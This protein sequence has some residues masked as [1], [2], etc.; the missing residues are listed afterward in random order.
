MNA[1]IIKRTYYAGGDLHYDGIEVV[2]LT[3]SGERARKR[4]PVERPPSRDLDVLGQ[5]GVVVP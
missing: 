1:P 2:I 4:R 3:P 5:I